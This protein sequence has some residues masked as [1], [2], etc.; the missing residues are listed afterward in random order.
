MFRKRKEKTEIVETT[1]I[2]EQEGISSKKEKLPMTKEQKRKLIKRMIIGGVIVIVLAGMILPK[3]FAPEILP[4]VSVATVSMG[5]VAQIIEGSGTVKSEEVKTYFSPVSATVDQFNL[6]VGDMVEAG[7]TLLTYDEKELNQLYK[8]AELTGSVANYGYQDAMAK[9][10]KNESEYARSSDAVN[11]LK[12]AIENEKETSEQ[13]Q[14]QIVEYT[15]KQGD[16]QVSMSQ[17]QAAASDAQYQ[18]EQAE[19]MQTAAQNRIAEI[20]KMLAENAAA[21]T[22][23]N[24]PEDT[25]ESAGGA[26]TGS[27]S[28]EQGTD[29]QED[30]QPTTADNGT[31]GVSA[32]NQEPLSLEKVAELEKEKTEKQN[33]VTA[34]IEKIAEQT[35]ARDA[36]LKKIE[37][38]QGELKSISEELNNYED[39]LKDSSEEME[40]LQTWKAKEEGIKDASDAAILSNEAKQQLAADNNLSSLNVLMTKE[41]I[42]EG[43][44]GIK[45]EFSGVVTEVSTVA[46]GPAAKGVSLF[47]VASNEKVV[48][49]MS[50]TRYDLEKLEVGQSA[51]ITLAGK[52]Y[53][54]TVSKLSRLAS[55]N[56]KGTPVVSA[57]IHIEGA[58]ENIY[59][60]LEAKVKV[61]GHKEENVLVVPVETVNTGKDGSFCYVVEDGVVVKKAVE[62]GLS[63]ETLVEIKSGL[64]EGDQVI[65][66]GT[67]LIEEG[68][69]V[70]AVEE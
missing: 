56:A 3:L 41:D 49:D 1:E 58:D 69:K 33:E 70:T 39:Q 38:L 14:D 59:L 15:G 34:A 28:G 13:V 63:S 40:R 35:A 50:V 61:N 27:T 44:S 42:N 52:S 37:S 19:Q 16:I 8:Q 31:N 21:G 68:M 60:G 7:E 11:V 26:D 67:E 55:A 25:Q 9:N 47:S 64:E 53:A 5:E 54:G 65:R 32:G 62:T 18:I 46:G 66:I 4:T 57:E 48:V 30:T 24:I 20:E 36:A 23:P 17:Y 22:E 45:A 6:K 51:E 12:Y 10:S 29:G 43:K 2:A